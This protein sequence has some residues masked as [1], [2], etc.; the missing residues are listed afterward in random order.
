MIIE[1]K[2]SKIEAG[3][4]IA[5]LIR[6]WDSESD[7]PAMTIGIDEGGTVMW[8]FNSHEMED[9]AMELYDTNTD[10][11]SP[12]KDPS[13]W[14]AEDIEAITKMWADT[15]LD[16]AIRDADNGEEIEIVWP[17]K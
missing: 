15:W 12:E 4:Q 7:M 2:M 5:E 16:D 11:V 8:W 13:D 10:T 1:M 17:A 14:D 3:R 9:M 6:S